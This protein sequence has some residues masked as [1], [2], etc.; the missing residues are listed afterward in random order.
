MTRFDV[1]FEDEDDDFDRAFFC[2][3]KAAA[4][5][6]APAEPTEDDARAYLLTGG[7][8]GGG[9]GGV[10]IETLVVLEYGVDPDSFLDVLVPEVHQILTHCRQPVAVAEVAALT[11]LPLGVVQLLA[12]D[13][14]GAGVLARSQEKVA[15]NEDVSFI[16]RL[17][18]GVSAL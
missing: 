1:P 6:S 8:T 4:P 5:D 12:G 15:L 3:P 7:R 18:S 9:S 14:V 10:A 17:I 2:L 13:L 16:E 11:G